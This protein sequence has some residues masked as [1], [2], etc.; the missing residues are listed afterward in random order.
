[1]SIVAVLLAATALVV[2]FAIPGPQ[3][4][5]G[6]AGTNGTNGANGTTGATGPRGPTGP[7]GN[8]TLMVSNGTGAT[9]ITIG[10]SCTNSGLLVN[11]TVP[12]SG[13]VVVQGSTRLRIGHT[14]GTEDRWLVTIGTAPTDCPVGA[15]SWLDSIG[16]NEPTQASYWVSAYAQNV[17]TVTAGTHLYYLN[18]YMVVGQDAS[19]VFIYANMVAVF[20][21][22]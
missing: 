12:K 4:L 9:F 5:P 7:A 10:A 21:P 19:D 18:A 1:M 16:T 6:A 20:Y 14:V 15:W 11:I 8:G 2:S 3:G 22:G 17:F 13:T